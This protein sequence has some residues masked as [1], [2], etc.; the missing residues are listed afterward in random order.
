MQGAKQAHNSLD[1][2]A[3]PQPKH[4]K[5]RPD[6]KITGPKSSKMTRDRRK[7]ILKNQP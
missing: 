3:E 2:D 1:K 7:T 5:C 6:I 4:Q